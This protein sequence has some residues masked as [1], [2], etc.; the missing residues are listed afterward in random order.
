MEIDFD[1]SLRNVDVVRLMRTFDG[2]GTFEGDI[3]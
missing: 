2:V 3:W 1:M